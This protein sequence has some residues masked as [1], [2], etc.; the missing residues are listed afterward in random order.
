MTEKIKIVVNKKHPKGI[1]NIFGNIQNKVGTYDKERL[2]YFK[3]KLKEKSEE[4]GEKFFIIIDTIDEEITA[5]TDELFDKIINSYDEL[6]IRNASQKQT[7][8]DT[9][10]K[11]QIQTLEEHVPAPKTIPTRSIDFEDLEP[12]GQIIDE[13]DNISEL[14]ELKMKLLFREQEDEYSKESDDIRKK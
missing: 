1:V 7:T 8:V 12:L 13:E 9:I 3:T 2:E 6:K 10:A 14:Q 11:E 4:L 5:V